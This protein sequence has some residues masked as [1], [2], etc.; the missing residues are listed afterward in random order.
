MPNTLRPSARD[1]I[2]DAAFTVFNRDASASLSQVADLAG[3]GRA[4]LHRYFSSRDS[5]FDELARIA[6]SEMDDAVEEAC[7]DA[8]THSEALEISMR[9]LIPLGNRHSFLAQVPFDE[10]DGLSQEFERLDR[11]TLD[12]VEEAKAEG[13]FADAVPT[14][15]IVQAYNHLLY[16]A[17]E[18]VRTGETT[19]DQAVALA[20]QTL[21]TG[22]GATP[23]KR[24]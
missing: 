24:T 11:E 23:A 13:L 22:L 12:L 10:A 3:V 8:K 6:I 15:W 17:W 5:L 1:A 21:T 7:K 20:W 9:V 16:A 19:Q 14:A 18:S 2:I 4:T